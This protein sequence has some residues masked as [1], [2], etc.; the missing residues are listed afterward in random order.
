MVKSWWAELSDGQQAALIVAAPGII[1]N[2]NGVPYATRT[3]ADKANL[4]AAF[5]DPRTSQETKDAVQSIYGALDA[6]KGSKGGSTAER[7]LV[8]FDLDTDGGK[9]LAAVAIGDLDTAGNVTWNVPGMGTTVEDGL[10]SWTKSAQDLY[11]GQLRVLGKPES[12]ASNAVVSWVG[13]DTPD[14]PPSGEVLST[15]KAKAGGEKLAAA[16]DGF[17]DTRGSTAGAA[18]SPSPT[19]HVV[20]HSYGT[21]TAS[22]ALIKTTHQVDSVTFLGS[23]GVEWREIGTAQDL[24][25]VRDGEGKAQVYVTAA[26]QDRVAPLGIGGSG[27][28]G[29]EGRWSPSDAWFGGNNFSSEGGYDPDTG[30]VYKRTTGH[31]AKGWAAPE[32]KDSWLAATGDHGYLDPDTESAHNIALSSTGRGGQ[33]KALIQLKHEEQVGHGG[34]SYPTGP[35]I[36]EDMAVEELSK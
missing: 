4:D 19:L 26:S 8:S 33:I 12:G 35:L 30:K 1:G 34:M 36:E 27:I 9:P 3:K 13:Y 11:D 22:S 29:R 20:A 16:L 25:V 2:L 28:R 6:R 7:G 32:S 24:H 23:A 14:G 18:G 10:D 17:R 31:D 15:E 21:T 5:N